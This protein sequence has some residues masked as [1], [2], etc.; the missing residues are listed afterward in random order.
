MASWGP[1]L[2]QD[3]LAQDVRDQ[4]KD[5]LKRGKSNE[6]VTNELIN[7]YGYALDDTDD[8]PIFW[9]ALADTQWN[10]GRLLPL[11]KEKAL[12]YLAS[13]TDLKRWELE[14]PK[15]AV[16]RKKVLQELEQKLNSPMPPEKKITQ[17]K[18][19]RCEWNKGDV[20]S[21][22]LESDYAKE[23][24]LYGRYFL[25]HKVD[26]DIWWPG[27]VVP[28][29]RVKITGDNNLP[30]SKA[31][32]DKLEYVRIA[33]KTTGGTLKREYLLTMISTSKRVIPKKLQY[34]ANYQDVALPEDEYI[35]EDKISIFACH[36]KDLEKTLIDIYHMLNILNIHP[37][38]DK[39]V[40]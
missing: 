16:V 24:D 12:E 11:V 15:E 13:G 10:L 37:N 1:K 7:S 9:F 2:Y 26:E 32:F 25:L 30:Q 31:E 21:Y 19:Y 8:A 23:K 39:P 28:I 5:Q 17:Y 4:Y 35:P 40:P 6:E 38:L 34:L 33:N 20:Y 14:N 36:W 27:H 29:V 3:D 18:F 22:K